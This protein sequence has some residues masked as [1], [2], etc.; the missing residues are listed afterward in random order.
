MSYEPLSQHN[1]MFTIRWWSHSTLTPLILT[2]ITHF[3]QHIKAKSRKIVPIKICKINLRDLC[4]IH[5][6][7]LSYAKQNISF[8]ST[9][10]PLNIILF[11]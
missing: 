10:P 8:A 3:R 6:Q 11:L 9:L 2:F 4:F 5:I 7:P 1:N